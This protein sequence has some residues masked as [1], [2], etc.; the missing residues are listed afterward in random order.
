MRFALKSNFE[1]YLAVLR[2]GTAAAEIVRQEVNNASPGRWLGRQQSEYGWKLWFVVGALAIA[3]GLARPVRR[4]GRRVCIR[5]CRVPDRGYQCG[6]C[7]R[8]S[9]YDPTAAGVYILTAP[10]NDTD[11]AN[12]LPLDHQPR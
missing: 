5:R 6:Q 10:D 9:R 1:P 2:I 7:E 12:G 11:G 3:T 8:W 4:G